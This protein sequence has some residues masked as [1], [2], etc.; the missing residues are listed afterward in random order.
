MAK[1]GIYRISGNTTPKVLEKTIY[2]IEEWYPDT[3]I[4]DR[5][6]AKV[7]WEL[8]IEEG[9]KFRT[10]HIK[11]KGISEFTFGKNAHKYTYKIEGYLHS[12]EGKSPM[13][14]IVKP[15]KNETQTPP[16]KDILGVS[17]T[18]QDGSKITKTLSYQDRLRATAKCQNLEGEFVVFQLWEDDEENKG[19][20]KKNQPIIK[21]PPIKVDTK[22]YARWNFTLL[23]TFIRLANMREDDKKNHEY[24]VTAEYNGKILEDSGNV[25]ITN[26]E[27]TISIQTK[28]GTKPKQP[29]SASPVKKPQPQVD[30]AKGSVHQGSKNNQPD[31][32]GVIN[33]IKLVDANGKVFNKRPK[34]GEKIKLIIEA[35][36]VKGKSYQLKI[37]E[38]DS[39]GDNDLLYNKT[40]TFTKDGGEVLNITLTDGMQKIG[41]IGNNPK[42]PDRGEY[43]TGNYQ[44]I[45][46][47]VI[48]LNKTAQ[49]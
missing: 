36:N 16:K 37:W 23:N 11:K 39:T 29:T 30:S 5:N 26:P 49:S 4:S 18:Y 33:S 1:K 20:N 31:K 13:A 48:Y 7:T 44:E 9:G 32:K 3:P 43:W 17:L 28:G 12:P 19:H 10:T 38:H 6:P 22:G 45:F 27:Y 41:E 34:F 35:K 21:S 40:H 8:F 15:Q 42:K 25:N 2:K 46:A 47:E 24:Y 14:L